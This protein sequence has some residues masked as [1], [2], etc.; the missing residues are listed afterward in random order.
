MEGQEFFESIKNK[1]LRLK[2]V[3]IH[4]DFL[5]FLLDED[6]KLPEKIFTPKFQVKGDFEEIKSDHKGNPLKNIFFI[7]LF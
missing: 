2:T 5:D 6:L 7:Y 4:T 3:K 1:C